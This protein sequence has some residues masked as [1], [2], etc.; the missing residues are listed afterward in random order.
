M[1]RLLLAPLLL[2]IS[3]CDYFFF[4]NQS[5]DHKIT[6]RYRDFIEAVQKNEINRVLINPDNATAEVIDEDGLRYEVN[7]APDKDLL[8]I[9]TENNV[10]IAVTPTRTTVTPK[11]IN[12]VNPIT[13]FFNYFLK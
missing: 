7:L 10:D 2:M 8:E 11:R 1:K 6:L 4:L 13:K 9:L 3:G 12:R 5:E